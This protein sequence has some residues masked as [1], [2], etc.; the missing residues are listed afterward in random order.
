MMLDKV[1]GK[2]CEDVLIFNILIHNGQR[3]EG[4]S[5]KF[6]DFLQIIDCFWLV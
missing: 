6:I 2:A 3:V 1:Q 4:G 5:P